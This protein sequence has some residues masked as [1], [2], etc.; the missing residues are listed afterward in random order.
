M[1][2]AC[3]QAIRAARMAADGQRKMTSA[4]VASAVTGAPEK[5]QAIASGWHLALV[6]LLAGGNAYRSA[7]FAEHSRAGLGPSR[8]V[9]YLR[10][11]AFELIFLAIVAAGVRFHGSSLQ[12][13]FGRRWRSAGEVL[14][15]LGIG[16]GLWLGAMVVGSV[17]SGHGGGGSAARDVSFLLPQTNVE[18][19]LWMALSLVAGIC[20]EAIFRGYL[21]RQFSAFTRSTTLGVI[22][23][24]LAFG[25]A[26]L[27]QGMAR[28]TVI[29][30]AAVLFGVVAEWRGT[31]RPG[32]AA[33]TLQDAIA[34]LLLRMMK[35]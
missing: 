13:I 28:A 14:K 32:M 17:L 18:L 27:Y 31:V 1:V 21:Q 35:R 2:L 20:E 4:T 22:L 23:A 6:V 25:T 16:A 5:R 9:M 3:V 12:A 15:D 19:L 26:H 11:I 30:T 33:H 24:A 7:V 8:S 29:A 10:T 34:P